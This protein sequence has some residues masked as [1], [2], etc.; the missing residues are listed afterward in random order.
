MKYLMKPTILIS[1]MVL[2]LLLACP[3]GA[4]A[5]EAANAAATEGL[6]NSQKHTMTDAVQLSADQKAVVEE[7]GPPESFKLIITKDYLNEVGKV[8]R[9][10]IWNYYSLKTRISFVDGNYE[11]DAEIEDVPDW[12]LLP[13]IYRPEQFANEMSLEEI[14]KR[15]IGGKPYEKLDISDEILPGAQLNLIGFE[16]IMLGFEHGKLIYA[17]TIPLF[18]KE[19]ETNDEGAK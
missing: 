3:P 9:I 2:A 4:L 1:I 12:T 6:Q 19:N 5:E 18:P 15:I 13:I 14:K 11:T 8:V 16:Q 10:E 7:F 17:E